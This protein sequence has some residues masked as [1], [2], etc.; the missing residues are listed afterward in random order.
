MVSGVYSGRVS[1]VVVAAVAV[2]AVDGKDIAAG[3]ATAAETTS[4]S[5]K[6]SPQGH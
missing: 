4:Y 3:I 5:W 2:V 1:V 6:T